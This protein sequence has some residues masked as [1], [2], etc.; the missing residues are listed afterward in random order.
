M[1]NLKYADLGLLISK[2]W[3]WTPPLHVWDTSQWFCNAVVSSSCPT[4]RCWL[5]IFI[6]HVK[7]SYLMSITYLIW[8][9]FVWL[10]AHFRVGWWFHLNY[11]CVL[12]IF[13]SFICFVIII[14]FLPIWHAK[15]GD[16]WILNIDIE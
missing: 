6:F 14:I 13:F 2:N 4:W 5:L 7:P 9:Q 11:H 16:G 1:W 8:F 10:W 3:H 15:L 12:Y